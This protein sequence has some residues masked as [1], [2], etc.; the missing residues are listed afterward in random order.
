MASVTYKITTTNTYQKDSVAK[1]RLEAVQMV[2]VLDSNRDKFVSPVVSDVSAVVSTG[3]I[4]RTIEIDLTAEFMSK[5]PTY[6]QRMSALKDL[7]KG[8]FQA[9]MPGTVSEVISIAI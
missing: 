9:V 4:E 6:N 2:V 7:L 3:V 5:F 8:H 1:N